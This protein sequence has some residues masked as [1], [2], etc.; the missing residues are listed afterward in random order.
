MINTKNKKFIPI[1]TSQA[2]SCLTID[3]WQQVGVTQAVFSL[4]ALI[5]KPGIAVLQSFR[6]LRHY[7]GW[8]GTIVLDVRLRSI[9]SSG[10]LVI[11]SPYDGSKIECSKTVLDDLIAHLNPDLE[12]EF[13]EDEANSAMGWISDQPAA[14]AIKGELYSQAGNIQILDPQYRQQFIPIDANCA[15]PTCHKGYTR[16]Y[17][18]HLLQQTPLLAQRL[19]VMHNV[20]FILLPAN[21]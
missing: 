20:G 5:A 2:G 8:P 16:A 1:L 10:N 7:S 17:L 3:N 9:T 4:E 14:D 6:D 19:L 11:R 13:D 15:C 18:H 21:S 12:I